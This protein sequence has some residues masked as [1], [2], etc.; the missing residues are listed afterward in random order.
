MEVCTG[1]QLRLDDAGLF[2]PAASTEKEFV[3][4]WRR[5]E[6]PTFALRTRNRRF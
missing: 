6:T 2:I 3:V 4:E 1:R 5:I